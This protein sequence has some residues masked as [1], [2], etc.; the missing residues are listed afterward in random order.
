LPVPDWL[1]LT[2]SRALIVTGVVGATWLLAWRVRS[3]AP[4]ASAVASALTAAPVVVRADPLESRT[5]GFSADHRYRY[6]VKVGSLMS[7][8]DQARSF[9]FDVTGRLELEPTQVTPDAVTLHGVL[10]EPSIVSRVPGTQPEFDKLAVQMNKDGFFMSLRGGRLQELRVP[11]GAPALVANVYRT[12]AAALQV[13]RSSVGAVEYAAQ[14]YD[15]TGKYLAAYKLGSD[16]WLSKPKTRYLEL[17]GARSAANPSPL[18]LVPRVVSSEGRVKLSADGRPSQ[19]SMRDELRIDGAQAPV[20]STT[21]VSL[22]QEGV[23]PAPARDLAKAFASMLVVPANDPYGDATPADALDSSRINGL[24]F[25]EVV[26]RLEARAK[27]V[28]AVADAGS[29]SGDMATPADA[30]ESKLFIAL[31]AILRQQPGTVPL[32]LQKIRSGA[33]ISDVLLDALG[34]A[35]SPATQDALIELITSKATPAKLKSRAGSVLVRTNHPTDRA[36]AALKA[37]LV[38]EPWNAKA[39]Y[40]LGTFSR[41]LRE[42]GEEKRST[43]LGEFLVS[44]LDAAPSVAPLITMLRS[45]ANS[46]YAG[47]IPKVIP[48]LTDKREQVRV[49]AVRS[50]Q[51]MKDPRVDALIVARISSDASNPVRISAIHATQVREPTDALVRG[52]LEA[53]TSAPDPHVRYRAVDVLLQWVPRRPDLRAALTRLS[54]TDQQRKIRDRIAAALAQPGGTG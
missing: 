16:G 51:S 48:L 47:A 37:L 25:E 11:R 43:E 52:L 23:E 36:I 42:A 28:H 10:L 15:S 35:S 14:E 20:A 4:P 38:V 19:V 1:K 13:S 7:L 2:P 39:L 53:A 18:K 32:A 44:K 6:R 50:L 29:D 49:D 5:R 12:L 40:G 26:K 54:T 31:A 9:D 30:E 3:P 21:T 24:T 46:G 41:R 27:T 45:L 33:A 34:S 22:E 8:G 17:L